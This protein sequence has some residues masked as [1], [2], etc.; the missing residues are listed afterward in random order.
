MSIVLK[1]VITGLLFF[2]TIASGIWLT[3]SGKPLNP[4]IFNVHKLMALASVI[5]TIVIITNFFKSTP[6]SSL[7]VLVVVGAI[8]SVLV[9]FISGALISVGK[10]SE[11]ILLIIHNISTIAIVVSIGVL[12]WLMFI[13]K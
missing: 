10:F 11:K 13:K 1:I 6:I 2:L 4:I 12:I 3:H 9:I 8:I 7:I 5:F